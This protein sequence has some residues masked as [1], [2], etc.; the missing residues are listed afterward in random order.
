ML[1]DAVLEEFSRDAP[2][3]RRLVA[4]AWPALSVESKLQLIV[5][6]QSG[7]SVSTA[8]WL[9]DLAMDDPEPIVQYMALRHTSLRTRAEG[10]PNPMY[11]VFAATDEEVA[12]YNKAH[13]LTHPLVQAAVLKLSP[14]GV[15]KQLLE[16]SQ[17]DRLVA[18]RNSGSMDFSTFMDWLTEALAAGIP[19]EDLAECALEFQQRPD[20]KF[21]LKK[22]KLD[23]DTGEGAYYAG[24]AMET[25]WNL[26]KRAGPRLQGQ[27]YWTMPTSFGMGSMKAEDLATV[28]D[29]I[30]QW[31]VTDHNP[32]PE[33]AA[34]QALVKNHPE[35]F[36]KEV[37]ERMERDDF[38]FPN[39]SKEEI[40][41]NQRLL[42]V[43]PSR[44]TLE[45]VLELKR[46]IKDLKEQLAEVKEAATAKRSFFS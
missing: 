21:E 4:M 22:G 42:A 6:E 37:I 5:A 39:A 12:Q 24:K 26:I 8:N 25:G 45:V 30:L 44:Q 28:P 18:I 13:A 34:V 9:A 27:L 35:R 16:C 36:S 40:A 38:E 10:E 2:L 33:V 7:T 29:R 23:F 31:M 32:S 41:D 11:A 14:L 43:D 20:T 17:T 19:D 15:K 1:S 3:T 46:Q